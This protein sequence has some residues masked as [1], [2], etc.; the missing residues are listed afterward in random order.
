VIGNTNFDSNNYRD[1]CWN[2]YYFYTYSKIVDK[3][4][5]ECLGKT[6]IDVGTSYGNWY[7]FLEKKGFTKV[8]GIELDTERASIAEKKGYDKIYNCDAA[9]VPHPD[10][11]IN[12]AVSNDVFVHILRIEDKL[13]VIREITRILK[14]GGIFI[15][16]HTMARAFGYNGYTVK[17]YCS[18]L[19]LAEL[20]DL[21][22]G[23][24][25]LELEDIKPSY[26]NFRFSTISVLRQ[27]IRKIVFIPMGYKLLSFI[28]DHYARIFS[29]QEADTI[30]IK[31][32]KKDE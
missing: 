17:D 25:N 1:K 22:N 20:I 26:F 11:S 30:Y 9:N 21:L 23:E 7:K 3:M 4:M 24:A 2:K 13:A 5:G 12:V 28:D 14:P 18:Y 29:L 15:L 16:N 32:R 10:N 27:I 19:N 8:Y 31:V 6:V